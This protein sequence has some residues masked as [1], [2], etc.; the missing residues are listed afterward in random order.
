MVKKYKARI[1]GTAALVPRV[2]GDQ[3]SEEGRTALIEALQAAGPRGDINRWRPL[4]NKV[5]AGI[6]KL[7][8]AESLIDNLG[9]VSSDNL[10]LFKKLFNEA[11]QEIALESNEITVIP[12]AKKGQKFNDGPKSNRLDRLGEEMKY[13]WEEFLDNHGKNP[14]AKELWDIVDA[15]FIQEKEQDDMVIFWESGGKEKKTDFKTFQKRYTNLK[16]KYFS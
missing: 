13:R 16:K 15:S 10:P 2:S 11:R 7:A 8:E 1:K 5:G 9:N 4:A 6:E 3:K 14:K 12:L